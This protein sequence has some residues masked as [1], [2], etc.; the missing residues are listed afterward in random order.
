MDDPNYGHPKL[1]ISTRKRHILTDLNLVVFDPT[2]NTSLWSKWRT[3]V[4]A[5]LYSTTK[6]REQHKQLGGFSDSFIEAPLSEYLKVN[7]SVHGKINNMTRPRGY[8]TFF[9]LN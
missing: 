7:K 6:L 5:Q 9:M 2:L 1:E 8:K 4:N 3:A